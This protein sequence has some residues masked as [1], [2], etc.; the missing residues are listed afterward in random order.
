MPNKFI[1]ETEDTSTAQRLMQAMTG[2]YAG[3]AK[4]NPA[5]ATVDRA[6]PPAT[7]FPG[8][9]AAQPAAG[10]FPGPAAQPAA[11]SSL[12]PGAFGAPSANGAA[13]QG[14]ASPE[15]Q[16]GQTAVQQAMSVFVQGG[17][18]R[19]TAAKGK[20]AEF[21]IRK[22]NELN[23]LNGLRMLHDFFSNPPAGV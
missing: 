10:G 17:P 19:A 13:A 18:M 16:Q 23:D 11:S 12:G 2:N 15:V 8:A 3:T 14:A 5:A 9:G 21:G 20:L 6:L 1:F 4:D 7:T 22:V